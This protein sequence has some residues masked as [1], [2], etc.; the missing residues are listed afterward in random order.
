MAKVMPVYHR[1]NE[2]Q[3]EGDEWKWG[4]AQLCKNGDFSGMPDGLAQFHVPEVPNTQLPKDWYKMT[5]R[6]GK[7][8]NSMVFNDADTLQGGKRRDDIFLSFEDAQDLGVAEGDTLELHNEMGT[9]YGV[10]RPMEMAKG[11]LQTYWPETNILIERKY[12]EAS[13]EPD[14]NCLVQIRKA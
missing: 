11:A 5:T 10:A 12:D 4:G 3:S 14:Y 7:Q 8:F 13:G 6:R 2:L 1:I 9:F